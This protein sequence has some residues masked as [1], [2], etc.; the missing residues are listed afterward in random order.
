MSLKKK[1]AS[2][3]PCSLSVYVKQVSE[4]FYDLLFKTCTLGLLRPNRRVTGITLLRPDKKLL[5]KLVNLAVKDPGEA[6]K[7]IRSLVILDYLPNLKHFKTT[8]NL[9][10]ALYKKT[11]VVKADTNKVTIDAGGKKTCVVTVDKNFNVK[12]DE[13]NNTHRQPFIVYVASG[14]HPCTTT[15]DTKLNKKLEPGEVKGGA[16]Y[17]QSNNTLIKQVVYAMKDNSCNP[18][19]EVLCAILNTLKDT[20]NDKYLAVASLCSNNPLASLVVVLRS[21]ILDNDDLKQVADNYNNSDEALKKIFYYKP[22]LFDNYNQHRQKAA[23]AF[24]HI[25]TA[26]LEEQ[27]NHMDNVNKHNALQCITAILKQV[28]GKFNNE[29]RDNMTC[30]QMV[31]IAELFISLTLLYTN[32]SEFLKDCDTL[33]RFINKFDL[34]KPVY[35]TDNMIKSMSIENMYSLVLMVAYGPIA[36]VPGRNDRVKDGFDAIVKCLLTSMDVEMQPYMDKW[37]NAYDKRTASLNH[38]LKS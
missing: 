35:L 21:K 16:E 3:Q 29:Y 2:I 34:V 36:Y 5:E 10:N 32:D 20:D 4:D 25:T 18:A 19:M 30:S 1:I 6:I 38:L 11:L 15:D 8:S 14:D 28:K 22:D 33:L 23:E 27:R 26:V 12:F 7:A 17:A 13:K 24:E 9:P 37:K 31:A